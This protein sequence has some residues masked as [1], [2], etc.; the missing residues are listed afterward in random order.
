MVVVR[1]NITTLEAQYYSATLVSFPPACYYCGTSEECLVEDE[2]ICDL[3]KEYAVVRLICFL[4]KSEGKTPRVRMAN[5][6]RKRLR[7]SYVGVDFETL[8]SFLI[9]FGHISIF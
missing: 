1:Q 3:R 5:D 9:F 8:S 2:R 6:V 4:C 7:L